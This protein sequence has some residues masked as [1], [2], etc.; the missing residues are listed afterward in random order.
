M[1]G[2]FAMP[3]LSFSLAHLS[4]LLALIMCVPNLVAAQETGADRGAR[5]NRLLE[6]VVVTARKRTENIQDVPIAITAF[7]NEKLDAA[8]V[9]T[10]Q[11]LTKITPGLV[12]ANTFG[13]YIAFLR[14]VGSEAFLPSAD[15]S[16]PI[17]VDDINQVAAQGSIDALVAIERV[18]VLKGPQGT[19]FGRNALGGAIRIITPEPDDEAFYGELKLDQGQFDV[20]NADASSASLFMNL[21]IVEDFAATLSLT[22]RHQEALVTN[23]LGGEV[24]DEE[25]LGGRLKLKWWA[26]DHLNLTLSAAHE[27]GQSAGGLTS[28]GTNPYLLCAGCSPDPAFDYQIAHNSDSG[29]ESERTLFSARL[30]WSFTYFDV[31]G[32]ISDQ[33]LTVPYGIGDLDYTSSPVFVA[34]VSRQFVEQKTAEIRIESNDQTPWNDYLVWVA[35]AYYLE[36]AGGYDPLFLRFG[37]N[38][39]TTAIPLLASLPADMT[40]PFNQDL[41]LASDGVLETESLSAFAEATAMLPKSI[42]LSLGLRYDTEA[43]NVVGSALSAASPGSDELT[44]VRTFEVPEASTDRLSPRASVK[45]TFEQGQVYTSYSIGY[46][47]PTY[48]TVNFLVAPSFVDQEKDTA[49]ELGFKG[50][51]LE[52]ALSVEGAVFYTEREDIIT[53]ITSL[54][55]GG[56]VNF[57]NGGD[58]VVKGAELSVQAQPLPS[59]NPGLAV[60]AAATYLDAKYENY[61]GGRGFDEDTGLPFGPDATGEPPRDFS[62]NDIVNTPDWTVSATVLQYLPLPGDWGALELAADVY[63]N[64]GYYFSAQNTSLVEQSS[65]HLISAR[66]GYFYDPYGLQITLYGENLTDERYFSSAV[67]LDFGPGRTLAAPRKYGIRAKWDF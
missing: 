22:Q 44:E 36:S 42:D 5:S 66:I 45:W 55:S 24:Y 3:K 65:Y 2:V 8:G 64:A 61:P 52:G 67:N 29:F 39:T 31:I 35:G 51:W 62:G 59:R 7:T 56:A 26:N 4:S 43:R 54:A 38:A 48:N 9:D 30:N 57:Y 34:E 18:E 63:Y 40:D 32:L 11:G 28:E 10:A 49:Y 53:A 27:K 19:L 1:T 15:P 41:A 17:Y 23:T 33:E 16:V 47:S 6:E 46:L 37:S 14:G 60:I 20:V 58:G 12:F 25:L 13:Y 21:P 50:S